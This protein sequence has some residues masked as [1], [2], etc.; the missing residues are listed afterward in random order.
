MD[1]FSRAKENYV[2]RVFGD[3]FRKICYAVLDRT[4]DELK[5][6]MKG[7]NVELFDLAFVAKKLQEKSKDGALSLSDKSLRL[8]RMLEMA[9]K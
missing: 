3:N 1:T 6:M 5:E 2:K 9:S 8:L 7:Q 4:S